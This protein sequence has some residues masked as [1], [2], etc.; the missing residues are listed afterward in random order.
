MAGFRVV[1]FPASSFIA[2]GAMMR[3]GQRLFRSSDG[4]KTWKEGGRTYDGMAETHVIELQPDRLLGA[5]RFSGA[6]R[7]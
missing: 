4:G 1:S 6:H 2:A 7:D 3:P 5:F